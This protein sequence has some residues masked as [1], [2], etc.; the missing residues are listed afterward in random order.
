MCI[1]DRYICIYKDT[2]RIDIKNEIDW[3]EHQIFVKALFPVDIHT[4]EASF[5]IQYGN[6]KRPTHANTSWDFAK[7]EVCVH[8]WMDVSED[9]YGVSVLN[10]CKYGCSVR[11]G[12]KM[13]IRDRL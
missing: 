2:A 7:F 8:K 9:G 10:D 4:S 13:C 1:R 5:E 12:V 11:D 6:V 3:R